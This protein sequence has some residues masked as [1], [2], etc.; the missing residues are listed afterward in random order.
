MTIFGFTVTFF[1]ENMAAAIVAAND[2][3]TSAT[4]FCCRIEHCSY[5]PLNLPHSLQSCSAT[6]L[7]ICI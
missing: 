5:K 7:P 1:L 4:I 2:A 3:V 6:R